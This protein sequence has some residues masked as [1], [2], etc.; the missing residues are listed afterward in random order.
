[1]LFSGFTFSSQPGRLVRKVDLLRIIRTLT[2]HLPGYRLKPYIQREDFVRATAT[3]VKN[4]HQLA[5]NI[6]YLLLVRPH[7]VIKKGDVRPGW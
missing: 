1:M 3:F 5:P 6:Q 4:C 2:T 7:Q